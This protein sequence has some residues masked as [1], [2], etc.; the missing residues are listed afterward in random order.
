MLFSPDPN[1]TAIRPKRSGDDAVVF[2]FWILAIA[3]GGL[4]AWASRYYIDPDTISY[5]D[6]ADA[7]LRFLN[8]ERNGTLDPDS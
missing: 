2:F 3:L 4:R 1:A 6:M 7:Y 5:L 8:L